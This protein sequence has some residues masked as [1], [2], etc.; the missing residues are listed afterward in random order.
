MSRPGGE[1][2]GG[3]CHNLSRRGVA[4][5]RTRQNP[6]MNH[7]REGFIGGATPED[8]RDLVAKGWLTHDAM[9]F[10]QSARVLGVERAND[11]NRAAIRAMATTE[12]RRLSELTGAGGASPDD[13]A[14]VVRFVADGTRLVTPASV[15]GRMRVWAGDD[16]TLCWE[17]EP[18]EC[19]A[20][21]GMSRLG[22]I[23]GYRCGVIY[24]V[25]CWLDALGVR[26]LGAPSVEGCLML[27]GGGCTGSLALQWDAGGSGRAPGG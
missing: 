6:T 13:T 24:R 27:A 25:E 18:G 11:L 21:K 4:A 17:W 22:W 3:W 8:V 14:A 15:A 20:F 23:D 19:F 7:S 16:E 9:W 2:R 1:G 5:V 10:D 26:P 12:V